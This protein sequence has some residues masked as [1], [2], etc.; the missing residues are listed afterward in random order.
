MPTCL[1]SQTSDDLPLNGIWG[2]AEASNT[3]DARI[4]VFRRAMR[5][6]DAGNP[7]RWGNELAARAAATSGLRASELREMAPTVPRRR[8]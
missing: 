2:T 3:E 1:L 7:L 6:A 5:E 4:K 8:W